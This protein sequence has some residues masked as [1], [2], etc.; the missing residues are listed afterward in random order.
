MTH[1]I[2]G[3]MSHPEKQFALMCQ[4]SLC[5]GNSDRVRVQ[6]KLS[7][8]KDLHFHEGHKQK[9]VNAV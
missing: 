6:Q 4:G 1:V 8:A 3:E 2:S 7:I 9:T 5:I